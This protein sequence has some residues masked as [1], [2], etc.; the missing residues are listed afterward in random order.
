MNPET[1]PGFTP[2]PPAPQ[3]AAHTRRIAHQTGAGSQPLRKLDRRSLLTVALGAGV[4]IP[5]P[6][7]HCAHMLPGREREEG[8]FP[9]PRASLGELASAHPAQERL[10]RHLCRGAG[11]LGLRGRRGQGRWGDRAKKARAPPGPPGTSTLIRGHLFA[12][13]P[14]TTF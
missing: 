13:R 6:G 2:L 1:S 5:H 3:G 10:G 7:G 11:A 12:L 8:A 4:F 9:N 14:L